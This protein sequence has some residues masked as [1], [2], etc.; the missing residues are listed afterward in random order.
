MVNYSRKWKKRWTKWM[1]IFSIL[2]ENYN[3]YK[4]KSNGHFRNAKYN[5]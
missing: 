4:N 1:K 5:T 3:I 2:V